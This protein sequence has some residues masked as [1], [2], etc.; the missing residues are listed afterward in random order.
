MWFESDMQLTKTDSLNWLLLVQLLL[1]LIFLADMG[2]TYILFDVS[3][4]AK[5]TSDSI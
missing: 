5:D 4:Y 3:V 2:L 1:F